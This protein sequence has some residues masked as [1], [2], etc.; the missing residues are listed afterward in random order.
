MKPYNL[1]NTTFLFY[2]R[3]DS[4]DRIDN[5]KLVLNHIGRY[6]KT[7]IILIEA[8]SDRLL[9]KGFIK[10]HNV[11][12]H[13]INDMD[14]VFHT[15][16]YRNLLIKLCE[17]P[18]FFICDAD[19]LVN[20]SAII[21]CVESMSGSST[22]ILV[23]PYNGNFFDVPSEHRKTYEKEENYTELEQCESSFNLWF[24]YSLGGIFG[25]RTMDFDDVP[26]DNENIY[27]WGPD[28]KERYY[29]LKKIGFNVYRAN[30]PLYHLFHTRNLNSKPANSEWAKKNELEYLKV[31]D[32]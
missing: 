25:G 31:F 3:I 5:L 13:Y 8:S 28:D 9:T 15:T 14:E 19:V 12:Y 6:F 27:G 7:N 29:R 21:D 26:L 20:P 23:Y 1:S 32:F 10:S 2:V 30:Y 18:Y 22:P 4:Q 17:S 16:K 24:K 11:Q